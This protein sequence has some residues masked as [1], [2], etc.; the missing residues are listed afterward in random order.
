MFR[1][2]VMR[3]QLGLRQNGR[4]SGKYVFL[5]HRELEIYMPEVREL[6]LYATS[7]L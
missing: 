7:S 5:L 1:L 4:E 2:F 6:L 3:P